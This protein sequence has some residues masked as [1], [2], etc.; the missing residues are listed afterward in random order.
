MNTDIA[1][2]VEAGA[3]QEKRGGQGSM[4]M[5][6]ISPEKLRHV[7][8]HLTPLAALIVVPGLVVASLSGTVV[9]VGV[10]LITYSVCINYLSII[11]ANR[12]L[13]L[14]SSIRVGSNYS[15]NIILLWLL[16]SAWPMAWVLLLLMSTGIALY[17]SR[18][19]SLLSSTALALMLL[20]VHW[21]F[22]SHSL[23]EWT[24]TGVKASIIILFNL[25]VNGLLK[26]AEE[27][28]GE[29]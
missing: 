3:P 14:L 29:C 22:G 28:P 19:D 25:F 5:N 24:A 13:R 17:Q 15:V 10:I 11:L 12:N 2:G 20:A 21:N 23:Q 9:I 7:N 26:N 8:N 18:R 1:E 4:K 16:Y 27:A 6:R